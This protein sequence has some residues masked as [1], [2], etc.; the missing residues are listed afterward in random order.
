MPPIHPFQYSQTPLINV[1]T[2]LFI[3]HLVGLL[4]L[5]QHIYHL[6]SLR[7]YHTAHLSHVLMQLLDPLL[8]ICDDLLVLVVQ[9]D[10]G[11]YFPGYFSLFTL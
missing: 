9:E 3:Y 2:D 11:L 6:R 4:G 5:S 8:Q 1:R 7:P 10:V